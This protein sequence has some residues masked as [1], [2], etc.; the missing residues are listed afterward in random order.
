[1]LIGFNIGSSLTFSDFR[2]IIRMPRAFF[3]GLSLQI[4]FL[5]L[6]TVL[7]LLLWNIPAEWK[8]GLFILSL[9]PGGSTSNFISYIVKANVALSIALTSINSILILFTIPFLSNIGLELYLDAGRQVYLPV[10]DTIVQV[11]T[12]ILLPAASGLL[13]NHYFP[14]TSQK[15]QQPMKVINILL[16]AAVYGIKFFGSKEQGG[17]G[18]VSEEI[19]MLLPVTLLIHLAAMFISYYLARS[20]RF[21]TTSATT[22]GIEVGLQNTTLAILVAGTLLANAEMTKPALVYTLFS[23]FTTFAFGWFFVRRN[24]KVNS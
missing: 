12:I 18:I 23:F 14:N 8:V 22:I 20:A 15:L 1:M 17:S 3:L 21:S 13:F 10:W 19:I 2:K 6:L 11:F 5:P 16:L 24:A 7:I 4:L 9:C